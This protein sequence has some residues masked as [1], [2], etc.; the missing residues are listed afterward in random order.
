MRRRR[1]GFSL[2]EALVALG[3]AAMTLAAIFELQSQMTQGQE[4]AAL[5]LQ[6]V[7]VQ[8]NA[9]AL[10]RDINPMAQPQG[11][12]R[13]GDGATVRWSAVPLGAARQNAGFP[14]GNGTFDV[15]I[16][17]MTVTV[18]PVAGRAPRPLV[19]ERVGWSRRS[20]DLET[21]RRSSESIY[22]AGGGASSSTVSSVSAGRGANSGGRSDARSAVGRSSPMPGTLREKENG[23]SV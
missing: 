2:I 21:P 7:V 22:S 11:E 3:I 8:E 18:E 4:R 14:V 9:L 13:L 15:Q 16:Y 20:G 23:V 17:E 1:S 10:T 19:F 5:A 6:Q 12:V